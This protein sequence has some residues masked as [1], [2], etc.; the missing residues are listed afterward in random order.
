VPAGLAAKRGPAPLFPTPERFPSMGKYA[1][2][3][4]YGGNVVQS[5]IHCHQVGDAVRNHLWK[6]GPLPEDVLFPYPHPKALGL[7]LD[8]KEK[9]TVLRVDPGSPAEAAGFKAGDA[10]RSMNGQ[11]LLSIADVQWVLHRTPPAGGAVAVGLRRGAEPVELTWTLPPGWRRRDDLS[12]RASSWNYRRM[13]TGGMK[14]DALP[15]DA[16]PAGVPAEGMALLA[17]HVGEF[18]PHAAAKNAGFR[19][20]DVI[21]SFDGRTD[22][23][24]ETDLF[25][26]VLLTKRPGAAVPVRV[27]RAGRPLDLK[28]PVQE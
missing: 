11:S 12:W 24:R 15:A 20:D 8:P 21:V 2:S 17:K 19:R 18:G 16:R 7:I 6:Q 27:I 13:A 4:D 1:P 14:L 5:C 10:I 3:I 9:A 28:L 26:H 23:L 22:L 25:A